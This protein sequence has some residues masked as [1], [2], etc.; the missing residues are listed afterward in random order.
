M[1]PQ[2]DLEL[3]YNVSHGVSI[4]RTGTKSGFLCCINVSIYFGI[5]IHNQVILM[6]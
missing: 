4:T 1:V 2:M 3:W 5:A 6:G